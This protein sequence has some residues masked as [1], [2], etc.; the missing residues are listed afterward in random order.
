MQPRH[1]TARTSAPSTMDLQPSPPRRKRKAYDLEDT[2]EV[3]VGKPLLQFKHF[4]IYANVFTGR[5]IVLA[6]RQGPESDNEEGL[7]DLKGEDPE[8]FQ[9]YLSC[10]Y[11][12]P[13]TLE[14]AATA[15]LLFEKLIRLYLLAERL[16]DLKTVNIATDEITR[17]SNYLGLIPLQGPISLA[18]ASTAKYNP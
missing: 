8:I 17:T 5:S 9:A 18:Y 16:I 3:V 10:V 15:D 11:F 13:E 14:R 4:T 7:V 1:N 12:G 6:A 2:F